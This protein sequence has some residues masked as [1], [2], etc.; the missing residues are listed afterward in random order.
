[1]S[2]HTLRTGDEL[3]RPEIEVVLRPVS[4]P[5]YVA[6]IVL[7][8][9]HDLGTAEAVRVSLAPLY[10]DV[11]VDFSDCDFIDSTVI[12]TLIG[13]AKELEREGHRLECIVPPERTTIARVFEIVQ[14]GQLVTIR[15]RVP[16]KGPETEA[17]DSRLG[18][19]AGDPSE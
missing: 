18:R 19:R 13:K 4:L 10:G 5:S 3:R 11:L 12:G 17:V 9:E 14:L 16:G 6:L 8:G 7:H 15:E 2:A 1:M